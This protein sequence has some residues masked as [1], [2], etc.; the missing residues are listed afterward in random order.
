MTTWDNHDKPFLGQLTDKG[1][2]QLA[3]VGDLLRSRYVEKLQYLPSEYDSSTTKLQCHST[4]MK[5]T[6]ESADCVLL[7]LY[8]ME[9][10]ITQDIPLHVV[11]GQTPL[12]PFNQIW[13]WCEE[14]KHKAIAHQEKV[15]SKFDQR[16]HELLEAV[17]NH[18]PS[19]DEWNVTTHGVAF[20]QMTCRLSHDIEDRP[21]MFTQ[22]WLNEF[23]KYLTRIVTAQMAGDR[24]SLK[25]TFGKALKHMLDDMESA[26][27]EESGSG[28]MILTS[29]H[30]DTLLA[31][32]CSV[33]GENVHES[34]IAWP[35]YASWIAFELWR[36]GGSAKRVVKVLYNG[37]PLEIFEG[38]NC[39]DLDDLRE[40]WSDVI[41]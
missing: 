21:S 15:M 3:A 22:Q 25:L 9:N 35:D 16:F 41:Q 26:Q 33:Y 8:P 27:N 7:N 2:Q 24:E 28:R 13:K 31:L 5:R 29:C 19:S 39:I 32:L 11:I 30:D 34:D 38:Q 14:L 40:Q 17:T 36:E 4:N 10:R 1:C 20:D 18:Y 37:E 23:G 6:I 12:Q